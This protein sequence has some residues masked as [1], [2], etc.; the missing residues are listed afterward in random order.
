MIFSAKDTIDKKLSHFK[1]SVKKYKVTSEVHEI[2]SAK[3]E[4]MQKF[5]M[6]NCVVGNHD[7]VPGID[8]IPKTVSIDSVDFNKV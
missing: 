6:P 7:E 8:E 3:K 4:K 5:L 2:K 1:K